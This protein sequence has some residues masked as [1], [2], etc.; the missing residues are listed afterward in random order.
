MCRIGNR[1]YLDSDDIGLTESDIWFL[2]KIT[3]CLIIN[4]N[5]TYKWTE[6]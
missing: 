1:I 2:S 6:D 4:G 3:G 5:D